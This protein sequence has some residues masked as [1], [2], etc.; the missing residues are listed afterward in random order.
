MM[1]GLPCKELFITAP[2]HGLQGY[3]SAGKISPY[4]VP[5]TLFSYGAAELGA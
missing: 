5:S 4:V 1:F 2:R 3:N